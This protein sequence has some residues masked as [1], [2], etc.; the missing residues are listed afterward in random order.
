MKINR[1]F[2]GFW[3]FSMKNLVKYIFLLNF[4]IIWSTSRKKDDQAIE[5]RWVL[6][7]PRSFC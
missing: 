6:D 2:C 4:E 1:K 5:S 7:I 3:S